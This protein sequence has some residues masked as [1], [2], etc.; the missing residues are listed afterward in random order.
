MA[1]QFFLN[2]SEQVKLSLSGAQVYFNAIAAA[3]VKF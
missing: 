3:C 1:G 2:E